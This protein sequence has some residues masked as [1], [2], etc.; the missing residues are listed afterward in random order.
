[1]VDGCVIFI[2]FVA[3]LFLELLSILSNRCARSWHMLFIFKAHLVK[4]HLQHWW[5]HHNHLAKDLTENPCPSIFMFEKSVAV[6]SVWML[7]VRLVMLSFSDLS[8]VHEVQINSLNVCHSSF[9]QWKVPNHEMHDCLNLWK[10]L[11][12]PPH[13][14]HLPTNREVCEWII[15]FSSACRSGPSQRKHTKSDFVFNRVL[16][17]LQHQLLSKWFDGPKP[18][19]N[20]H[21]QQFCK[22]QCMAY[23][24]DLLAWFLSFHAILFIFKFV[25]MLVA[26]GSASL[27]CWE[28]S[29]K[30]NIGVIKWLMLDNDRRWSGCWH[31]DSALFPHFLHNQVFKRFCQTMQ[32]FF[33]K[34]SNSCSCLCHTWNF[35]C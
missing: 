15:K 28:M 5:W 16:A 4:L 11:Q 33:H 27:F 9:F 7:G 2:W 12:Q 25:I 8:M 21:H 30:W 10:N 1:M 18:W 17:K 35:D 24:A 34:P 22:I 14:K 13:Y 26:A 19:C 6:T 3:N 32:F 20:Q 29:E 31:T 23:I